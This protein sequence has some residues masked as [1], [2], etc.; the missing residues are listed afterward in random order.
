MLENLKAILKI[1]GNDKDTE[2]NMWLDM[3]KAD[4]LAYT[5]RKEAPE[6]MR[7]VIVLMAAELYRTAGGPTEVSRSEGGIAVT[8]DNYSD[9]LKGKLKPFR[10][11]K[12]AR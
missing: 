5:N 6:G 10:I 3:A 4:A 2:L 8:W 11:L 9:S 7:P 12:L 1:Q